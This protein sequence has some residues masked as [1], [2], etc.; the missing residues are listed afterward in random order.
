MR[1][2]FVHEVHF[3]DGAFD[4]SGVYQN[5]LTDSITDLA[6]QL[7]STVVV[8]KARTVEVDDSSTFSWSVARAH[9][10][11]Y[12]LVV[13]EEVTEFDP[14]SFYLHRELDVASGGRILIFSD[15]GAFDLLWCDFNGGDDSAVKLADSVGCG[16]L[17]ARASDQDNFVVSVGG[18][19]SR[20]RALDVIEGEDDTR[21]LR[22]KIFSILSQLDV[23]LVT[24][25]EAIRT[26]THDSGLVKVVSRDHLGED[27]MVRIGLA[28]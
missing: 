24:T 4:S 19:T 17:E 18:S 28:F 3:I 21:A 27:N 11:E 20:E 7:S 25:R 15:H 14:A 10:I 16:S 8:S 22:S 9:V 6:T 13:V 5:T 1:I 23:S 26:G 12:D 2:A